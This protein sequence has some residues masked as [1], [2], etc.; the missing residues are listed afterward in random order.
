VVE[1]VHAFSEGAVGPWL[2][3]FFGIVAGGSVGLIGWRGDRLRSPGAI[4]SS[5]SREAAFLAN[6]VLFGALAFVVL[7]GTVF[8][9]LAEA[10]DGSRLTIGRPYFDSLSRPIAFVML[11]LMASAPVLPWRKAS[12]EL[13]AERLF[14]PAV[15]G[16]GAMLLAVVLGGRGL[17][18]V[19]TFGLGG[20][21]GGAALR[22]LILA[23]RRQGWRGL[24]GRTNGGMIVHIGVVL[25]AVGVAASESYK[26]D[27]TATLLP[28]ESVVVGDHQFTYLEAGADETPRRQRVFAQIQIDGD[29]VYAPAITRYNQ[30]G[31]RV[32]TPSVRT[33]F[34]EDVYLVLD[35]PPETADGPIRLRVILRPMMSWMWTGGGLMALGTLLAVFPGRRR[36]GTEAVS[37]LIGNRQEGDKKVDPDPELADV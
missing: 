30:Q 21:A 32:A 14:W 15:A 37:A 34:T 7:L 13:L 2:L 22:Q 33:G 6:N 27:R 17:Y 9:L 29:D 23:T 8:P 26:T 35:E 1:S 31:M 5:R 36:R 16:V 28:G 19:F 25:I 4:D 12:T 24:V 3:V 18:P 10:F 11:F 20:F